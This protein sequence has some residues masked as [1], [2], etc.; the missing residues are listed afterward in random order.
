MQASCSPEDRVTRAMEIQEDIMKKV[1]FL[2]KQVCDYIKLTIS[3]FLVH[4]LDVPIRMA[5]ICRRQNG[6]TFSPE[7]KKRFLPTP[8]ASWI[9][10]QR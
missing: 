3:V 6:V 7:A 2:E 5:D 1:E 4:Y 9:A 8:S 10:L